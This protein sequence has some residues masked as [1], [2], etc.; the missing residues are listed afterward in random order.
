MSLE[1]ID[2]DVFGLIQ[3]EE[4]RQ[5]RVLE[6][7]PSENYAS[8]AV[9][10]ALGSVL[11]NKYSEGYPGQRYYQGNELVDRIGARAVERIGGL[12]EVPFANVQAYSGSPAN[13]AVYLAC[14]RT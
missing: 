12:F 2:P 4:R 9:R 6:L 11:T 7:I 8:P 5:A 14:M 13:L 3:A 10:R 1:A